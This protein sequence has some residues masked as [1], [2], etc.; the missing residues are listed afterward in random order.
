MTTA[1]VLAGHGSHIT[2]ETAGVVWSQVDRLRAMR[3]ADEVTAAF[4]KEAPSFHQVLGTIEADDVTIVP[5]FTAQGYFTQTVIPTEMGLPHPNPS[6]NIGRGF[7]KAG[8]IIR[9]TRTLSEHP[10]LSQVVRQRIE[11]ALQWLGVAGQQVAVA[12][13]GH[14]TRR[15]PESRKATEAQAEQVR[16]WGIVAQVQ[17]VYLD[18]KPAIA[19]IYS[20]TDAPILI[21]VPFFLALGSHTT[22]DVPA[23]LGLVEGQTSAQIKG[24]MVYYT[25]PV[26]VEAA[27]GGVIREL[28]SESGMALYPPSDGSAWDSFPKVGHTV[29]LAWVA[30]EKRVKLGEL[31]ITL[32][33]VQVWDDTPY[34]LIPDLPTLR[35]V[36][37]EN[38]F[39]ALAT[40]SDLPRG[41]RI[42]P[43][44]FSNLPAIIETICPGV[45]ADCANHKNG[46]F[47][48]IPLAAT[49]ERQTGN[50]RQL[51]R[52]DAATQ[53]DLVRS[54]CGHCVCQPVWADGAPPTPTTI[55]CREA[56]NFWMSRALETLEKA[57]ENE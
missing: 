23:A 25:R 31:E 51:T 24:R 53:A 57:L 21:A 28:V 49:L 37:R 9:Y 41:W 42:E 45:L 2:P 20:L 55:P 46:N 12:V 27:L 40:S 54:I 16:Q 5:L 19:E 38:P 36:V 6:P 29:F 1:I 7:Q 48:A 17:A 52:L 14:S 35:R 33:G 44:H 8:R 39:R 32:D 10:Y 56:C 26:G 3:V 18:D 11:D 43:P 22:L 30:R 13:I 15:N 34:Q 47:E 4:W 50:Y